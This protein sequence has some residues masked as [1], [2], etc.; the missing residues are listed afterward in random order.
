MSLGISAENRQF[1]DDA[2]ASGAF[3]SQDAAIN[4]AVSLL[5][6]RQ[7]AIDRILAHP[8]PLPT[9]PAILEWRDQGYIAVRGRRIGL[10]LILDRHFSGTS[11]AEM[12]DWFNPLTPAE[13][14]EIL[15]FVREHPDAMRAYLD[16]HDTLT[17][18]LCDDTHRGPSMEEL[19]ARWQT[20]FGKPYAFPQDQTTA[21][22]TL[23]PDASKGK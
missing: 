21:K 20:K 11:Q 2:I 1:L 23:E 4:R 6:Q 13:I 15:T 16:Q 12:E 8:V 5:R 3:P 18:L 9:L 10:H 14:E 22:E 19:R 17:R 7:Q